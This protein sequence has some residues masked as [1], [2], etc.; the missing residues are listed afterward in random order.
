M[1]RYESVKLATGWTVRGS[2]PGRFE[3]FR[4]HPDRHCLLYNEYSVFPG[5]KE[6]RA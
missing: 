6:V 2:N 3:F 5:S 1:F 4:I